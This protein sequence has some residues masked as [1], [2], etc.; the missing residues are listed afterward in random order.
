MN[1]KGLKVLASML[2]F[3]LTF[4]YFSVFGNVIASNSPSVGTGNANVEFDTYLKDGDTKTYAAV[5]TI[6]EDN[7]LYAKVTV[8][9]EGYLKTGTITL[10][11]PNFD[12][13][14]EINS[15]YVSK[16]EGNVI[17]LNQINST[18]VVELAIPIKA[19]EGDRIK[20]EEFSKQVPISFNGTYVN[21]EGR[22][23]AVSNE[24]TVGLA[25]DAARHVELNQ[26]IERVIQ[27]TAADS[28]RYIAIQW[29]VN[30]KL[31]NN[32]LPLT[33]EEI[34][35]SLPKINSES[36]TAV[37]VSANSTKEING[38]ETPTSFNSNNYV[39]NS[40]DDKVKITVENIQDANG[41]ISWTKDANDE[42]IVTA[43]YKAGSIDVTSTTLRIDYAMSS[44]LSFANGT[45]ATKVLSQEENIRDNYTGNLVQFTAN[46]NVNTISKG[47]IYANIDAENKLETVYEETLEANVT[48]ADLITKVVFAQDADNFI[49]ENTTQTST[50]ESGRNNTYF[51]NIT[52]SKTNFEKILG[53][54]GKIEVYSESTLVATISKTMEVD[55]NGNYTVNLSS[56]NINN[57]RI[58]T[59]K[60]VSAGKL[61]VKLQKAIK[62]DLSYTINEIRNFR[63]LEMNIT[64]TSENSA[65]LTNASE[66]LTKQI[67][68]TEPETTAELVIDTNRLSTVA[69]NKDVKLTTVLRTDSL[70][71]K[72]YKDP[73]LKITLPSYIIDVNVKNVEVLF[74]TDGSNLNLSNYQVIDNQDGTKTIEV[75]L[76]GDQSV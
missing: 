30:T 18:N 17:Y 33:K 7:S 39:Y 40:A 10:R 4:S 57:I 50:T 42:Y 21:G 62:G 2:I 9:N 70:A 38:E 35:I 6:G 47:Q 74:G 64:A 45:S 46:T 36:A 54:D 27:Y 71:Y 73:T 19:K 69:A 22:E 29:K 24:I 43:V 59:T 13:A 25:W 58:E 48:F 53:Q 68:L 75:V 76:N 16:V 14:G 72:L 41:K 20:T 67:S 5:K 55:A 28:L 51:K 65:A 49:N 56:A 44:K 60:P 8:K 32:T 12:I 1:K 34:E 52:V 26:Q 3:M 61:Q 37:S 66:T 63:T 31:E 23:K 11:D 15:S